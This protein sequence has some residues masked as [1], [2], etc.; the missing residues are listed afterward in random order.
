M[1]ETIPPIDFNW[2]NIYAA[3]SYGNPSTR[4]DQTIEELKEKHRLYLDQFDLE[5]SLT[6]ENGYRYWR[7]LGKPIR[8]RNPYLGH[9][10]RNGIQR[11][12]KY[13]ERRKWN[14]PLPSEPGF[15][16]QEKEK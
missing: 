4:P 13:W 3:D 8:T 1:T 15:W 2:S 12:I 9:T 16:P 14:D 7:W 11:E 5:I 6:Q 10:D